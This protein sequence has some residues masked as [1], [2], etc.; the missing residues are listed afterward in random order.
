MAEL[1]NLLDNV[2]NIKNDIKSAIENKGQNITNF[3]SYPNA[4]LNIDTGINTSDA[5]ATATDLVFEK[6]A[7]VNGQKISG[8]I[9]NYGNI[10]LTP[11]ETDSITQNTGLY[12]NIVV[13]SISNTNFYSRCKNITNVIL[14]GTFIPNDYYE[15]EYIEGDG[16][17]YT[18]ITHLDFRRS[19]FK[20]WFDIIADVQFTNLTPN[21]TYLS[22]HSAIFGCQGVVS[23]YNA[24]YETFLYFGWYASINNGIINTPY[25]AFCACRDDQDIITNIPADTN[26]HIFKVLTNPRGERSH[27]CGFWVDDLRINNDAASGIPQ[28]FARH[29]RVFGYEPQSGDPIAFA[30]KLY[31]LKVIQDIDHVKADLIPAMRKSDNSVGMYDLVSGRFYNSDTSTPYIAGNIINNI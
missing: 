20:N 26:R 15:L 29:F 5:T 7:Y 27:N 12:T 19:S 18:D 14:N 4:I 31:R 22:N 9:V 28:N 8:T 1:N 23:R 2:L 16:N 24:K 6:T 10:E 13:N 25:W 11:Y 3:S 17:S 21:T 30:Q